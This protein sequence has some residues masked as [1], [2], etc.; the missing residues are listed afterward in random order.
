MNY[1]VWVSESRRQGFR[2]HMVG[3]YRFYW[4]ACWVADR[5]WKRGASYVSVWDWRR[6][7]DRIWF[8]RDNNR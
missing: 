4:Y 2:H 6:P 7:V 8:W 3:T 1:A 5:H